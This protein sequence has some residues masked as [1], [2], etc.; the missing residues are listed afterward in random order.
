[1]GVSFLIWRLVADRGPRPLL[2]EA[3]ARPGW[4][5]TGATCAVGALLLQLGA[6]AYTEIA[7]VE[8]IKRAIGVTIAMIAGYLLFG[9]RD[10]TRRL[11]GA[12]IMVGGVAMIFMLG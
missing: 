7:Y 2:R 3:R 6:Y 1:M 11:L 10:I 12:L 4:L 8:T 5:V 9:E